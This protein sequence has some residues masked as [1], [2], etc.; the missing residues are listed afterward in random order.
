MDTQ[1][2]S[3]SL[4]LWVG[5]LKQNLLLSLKIIAVLWAVQLLNVLCKKKL[6]FLG[7]IPRHPLGLIGI[8]TS[9]FL[10]VDWQHLLY[11]TVALFLL[12]NLIL[13]YGVDLY[14]QLTIVIMLI[15]GVLIWRFGRTAI[16]I[17]ASGVILGYWGFIVAIAAITQQWLPIA[18]AVFCLFYLWSMVLSLLPKKGTSWEGHLFG[19]LSGVAY[20]VFVYYNGGPFPMPF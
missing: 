1:G 13:T 8:V 10:H 12:L 17:G 19:C 18:I 11:N 7:I 6:N 5:L 4:H 14:I 16:H 2:F 9:P 15:S 20:A 3:Q